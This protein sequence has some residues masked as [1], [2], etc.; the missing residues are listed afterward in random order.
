MEFIDIATEQTTAATDLV[1][2][3]VSVS[4]ALYIRRH[5]ETDRWK[6]WLWCWIFALLAIAAVLGAAAH[7]LKLSA[8]LR[9][10][11]W[12]PLNL[13]LGLL[14]ALFVVAVV[15][16]SRGYHGSR[17][18]LYPM[19]LV[20][21]MF[22]CSTLIWPD[23]FLPFVIYQALAMLFALA[24]YVWLAL[25]QHMAGAWLM[26]VGVLLTMV[27]A[28]LQASHAVFFTLIWPFDH[29]GVYHLAQIAALVPLLAGLIKSLSRGSKDHACAGV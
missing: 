28:A 3:V 10:L 24:G 26:A 18:L 14:V 22:F 12:Q 16:D 19:L 9:A 21:G 29:N 2:A 27:A 8:A 4:A 20:G 23:D 17:Q 5:G 11:L 1:L 13:S 6:S 25:R 7:G 15:H